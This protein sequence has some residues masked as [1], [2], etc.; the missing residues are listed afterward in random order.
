MDKYYFENL[1]IRHG[2][3]GYRIEDRGKIIE[4]VVYNHL[5]HNGYDVKVGV[6]NELE[7]DFVCQK[8]G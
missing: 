4:N 2:I 1:G 8:N 6:L 3:H 7:I 5:V